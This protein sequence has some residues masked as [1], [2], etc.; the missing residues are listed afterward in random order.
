MSSLIFLLPLMF[1]RTNVAF[2]FT[3]SPSQPQVREGCR[4]YD[5][6][7]VTHSVTV[8]MGGVSMWYCAAYFTA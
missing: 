8:L 3:A 5:S 6:I 4:G 7:S 2:H 1:L